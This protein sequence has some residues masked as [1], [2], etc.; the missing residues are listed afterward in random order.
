MILEGVDYFIISYSY[1]AALQ[2]VSRN[3]WHTRTNPLLPIIIIVSPQDLLRGSGLWTGL[4]R[5]LCEFFEYFVSLEWNLI[6][7]IESNKNSSEGP[8]RRS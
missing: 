5:N 1:S 7:L 6:F 2:G 3:P 8:R 4:G